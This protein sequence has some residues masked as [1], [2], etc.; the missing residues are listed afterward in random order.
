M[1]KITNEFKTKLYNYFIKSLGAYKYK[2]GWMKLP[3]C[4]FCHREHKMGINLSMYRTNCFRCNYH[5]NPA[6]LV[7]D[8]EGFDTYAELLKF[9]DNGNFTDKAFSEEKIELSDAKPVYLPD[10]FK[11]INQGTS[12]VA[13]SIRSYM[14]SR[15]FT[16]EELS[17]HGIGYIATEGPFLGT[18]SYHIII[19]ARSGITMREMLLDRA[20]DTIIQIKILRDL[21]R[22]LL[23]SIKMPSTCIVRYLSVKEQSMHLLWETGL[24]PPWVRQSVLTKLTSLSN[25]QLI[26]LYYSWIPMPSNIQSIWLSNWS[27]IKRSRLYNFLKI[28]IVT[29]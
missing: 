11:L 27:L 23:S 17:K 16:I 7:M 28:K 12:Q 4:P 13:R 19:R 10:G 15:G 29:T 3:V 1:S 18:S 6:Q 26:D 9:L 25:L 20:Q 21:E 5:M 14:S 24:L 2:H 8:V 22:N